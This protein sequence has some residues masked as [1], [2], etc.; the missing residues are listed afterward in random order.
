[1]PVPQPEQQPDS[2]QGSEKPTP[3][4]Q[5]SFDGE[6]D[7]L[8]ATFDRRLEIRKALHGLQQDLKKI[9]DSPIQVTAEVKIRIPGPPDD[10][11]HIY[12]VSI[13]DRTFDISKFIG[14]QISRAE[15][16]QVIPPGSTA[17]LNSPTPGHTNGQ[18]TGAATPSNAGESSERPAKRARTDAGNVTPS[19]SRSAEPARETSGLVRRDDLNARAGEILEYLR[20]WQEQWAQQGGWM[21]DN[22][23]RVHTTATD[24]KAFMVQRMEGI[25][26]VLGQSI[27][28]ANSTVLN[29]L[30]TANRMLPWLEHCRK[31]AADLQ[32]EREEKWRSSSASFHDY[33]RKDREAAELRIFE[34]LEQQQ[35]LIESQ[36][37]LLV[38]LAEANGVDDNEHDGDNN[39]SPKPRRESREESLGAQL[40]RELNMEAS[41]KD[42]QTQ[43]ASREAIEIE[44]DA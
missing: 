37:K 25:Q 42:D 10:K 1:M 4:V 35:R 5:H 3:N 33:A 9:K 17:S 27:N 40:T 6:V 39:G 2:Q 24:N 21:F 18:Q 44:D 36:R 41:R 13:T 11:E 26:N 7:V 32:Q 23:T 28:A 14:K 22:V 29:E 43:G 8:N 12:T 31:T 19:M 16:E 30:A 34:R 20:K 38:K 15:P